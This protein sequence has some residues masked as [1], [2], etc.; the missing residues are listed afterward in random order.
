[1]IVHSQ[2]L[3][4]GAI[5]SITIWITG[6]DDL[7]AGPEGSLFSSRPSSDEVD[8]GFPPLRLKRQNGPDTQRSAFYCRPLR[9][10]R[11]QGSLTLI[12]EKMPSKTN[13]LPAILH[14][15]KIQILHEFLRRAVIGLYVLVTE[16]ISQDKLTNL[17][18]K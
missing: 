17:H 5:I 16:H 8:T 11:N 13:L 7:A 10:L 12:T 4:N 6:T 2:F 14:D 15:R 3:S 1:M 9:T 18:C